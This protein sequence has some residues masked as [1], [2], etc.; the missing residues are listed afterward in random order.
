MKPGGINKLATSVS[1]FDSSSIFPVRGNVYPNGLYFTHI[2]VG[3][4]PRPYFLDMD[5]GSDL[6]WIQCDAPCTSCAKGPNPLY[7]PKKG[8]LVP[9]KDSLCVEVQRNQKTGYCETCEQCDYEIEYADQSS[10]M[11][12]LASDDLHLMLANGSQTKLGIMFGCAYDQQ[13][14][15]LNSLAKT[16]GILG[17]SKAKVS[18]PSQ[19]ASQRIINNVL[20]H[21]LTSDASGGGYMFLGDDFVP[22]WGMAWVPMLNNHSPN[23]HTQIMKISHGSRQLSLGRQDGRTGRVVFDSGSSYTYFPK[24][25]YYDLV[26]SLKDVSDEGLIQDGSDPTLPVCWRAKFPIR[27]CFIASSLRNYSLSPLE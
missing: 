14:L 10:S 21:C 3:S 23:Y 26:A 27:F 18:L 17:L 22:Y 24:E 25:S 8:N 13:G 6:T 16:D 5:T 4:P 19:L 7:K 9:L 20:G 1:A 12:V 2:F 11:G 15:L